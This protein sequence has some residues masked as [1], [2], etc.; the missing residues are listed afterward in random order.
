MC[1]DDIKKIVISLGA[2]LCKIAGME[3]FEDAPE[4]Y[5]PRDVLPSCNSVISFACRFP[6]GT[7]ACRT[8]V[9]YTRGRNSITAKMDAIALDLCIE[10]EKMGFLEVPVPTNESQWDD[11]TGRWRSIVSQKHAAQAA[12]LGTI[13][14]H[15]LLIT[16]EF[17]SMVWLGTVLT[18][19][20]LAEDPVLEKICNDCNL[21]VE[22]C[23][24]NALEKAELN[25]Q[26]CWDNAFGDN[27]DT[28]NWEIYCHKCRDICPFNLGSENKNLKR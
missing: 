26:V 16:P 8:A 9:P 2:D 23:P 10:L 25:Q 5:H 12:G 17:G 7:L 3:R 27:E 19:A 20:E 24:H 13:G 14:R 28:R 1:S 22:A 21:C 15:S 18:E 11:K 6:A 4:G